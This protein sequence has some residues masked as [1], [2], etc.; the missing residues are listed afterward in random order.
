M[1]V[2]CSSA[3]ALVV[4]RI[5]VHI[6]IDILSTLR[7]WIFICHVR[8][9]AIHLQWSRG[10]VSKSSTKSGGQK[11]GPQWGSCLGSKVENWSMKTA[12][13]FF[14]LDSLPAFPAS[15]FSTSPLPR[16][17]APACVAMRRTSFLAVVVL[18]PNH[19]ILGNHRCSYRIKIL[20]LNLTSLNP[21]LRRPPD[22]Q[23]WLFVLQASVIVSSASVF[24]AF[25]GWRIGWSNNTPESGNP[26]HDPIPGFCLNRSRVTHLRACNRS[27]GCCSVGLPGSGFWSWK[28]SG[29]MKIF[30][31]CEEYCNEKGYGRSMI[32]KKTQTVS[33]TFIAMV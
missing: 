13:V 16:F 21:Q 8:E 1:P 19:K 3:Q 28:R 6:S 11:A 7:S 20:Q 30:R 33:P 14:L 32:P 4:R 12:K 22:V 24:V 29:W 9:Q 31:P 26:T 18:S 27:N 10:M 15:D 5:R 17:A 23:F 25:L 2:L